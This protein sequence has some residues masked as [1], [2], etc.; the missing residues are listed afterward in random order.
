MIDANG[1]RLA[2]G[3]IICNAQLELFLARRAY[4]DA[5]QFPQGG[6]QESESLEDALFRELYEEVGLGADDV[7]ILARSRGWLTYRLPRRLVRAAQLPLCIGQKQKWFLLE[8]QGFEDKIKLN[9]MPRPEFSG[10]RWV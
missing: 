6:L 5:W 2:V 7:K 10:W 3:I 9:L 8:L 1:F 4:Q